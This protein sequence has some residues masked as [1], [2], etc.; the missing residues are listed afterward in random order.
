MHV[1]PSPTVQRVDIIGDVHGQVEHLEALLKTLGY[2]LREGAWQH[3]TRQA[4]FVGDLIDKGPEPAR[5]LMT[6]RAM[7]E[8]SAARMVVGN[9]ELNWINDAY[10]AF[11]DSRAFVTATRRHHD[12]VRLVEG[13]IDA[14]LG[15]A[16]LQEHFAWLRRQP[17]FIDEPALRVV[18]ASWQDEAIQCLKDR[19]INCLDDDGMRH[20][21][22]TYSP[23][24]LAIDRVVAGCE[25]DFFDPQPSSGF[26]SYRQRVSWWPHDV[27]EIHPSELVPVPA[28][29]G[30]YTTHQPPVFF[31]HYAL[32]GEPRLLGDNVAG[33]D[34]SATYGGDLVAYRHT[35][36]DP[37]CPSRF[38]FVNTQKEHTHA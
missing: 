22:D 38:I 13:F 4:I 6:V 23:G 9:H 35:L 3:P 15:L 18:H 31:G 2:R 14:G 37:L 12:R 10:Q 7:V 33:V 1:Q 30:G 19:D 25:H 20:Y 32:W 16:G 26:R 21:R 5:V 29:Q 36:G 27:H 34:Y 8:R 24:Y 11:S 17:L 28:A